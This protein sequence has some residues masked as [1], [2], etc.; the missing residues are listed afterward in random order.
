METGYDILFFWVAR[1]IMLGIENT[2][3]IPFRSVYLHG[4]V[5]DA[6]GQKMSKTR[7]N[8]LDPL[9]LLE[10]YGTDAL[11]F[12][13]TT[14]TAPGNN[15]RLS[16]DKL[17]SA[18]NF[19]NKIWNA[20]RFVITAIEGRD[21]LDGWHDLIAPEH[22]EDRWIV[23]RLD[24]LTQAVNESLAEFELGEAQQKLYD[25]VWNDFCDWYI[26]MAKVRLRDGDSGA[27]GDAGPRAG[28]F[29]APVAPLHAVRYR[30]D[31]A[32]SDIP[33]AGAFRGSAAFDNGCGL[34]AGTQ[35]P[36]GSRCRIRDGCGDADHS[37]GAQ[38]ARPTADSRSSKI[39]SGD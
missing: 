30:G 25:F 10:Q 22:R 2:G 31:L 20:A 15:L 11:R 24:A 17:E 8:T 27:A 26:E 14:G 4:M 6:E 9:D 39:G 5:L 33:R 16:D 13:L 37:R 3:Q 7:G 21:D 12:A 1:M 23:G 36:L 29:V 32:E 38:H 19:A 28:A 18:R 35:R 34:P